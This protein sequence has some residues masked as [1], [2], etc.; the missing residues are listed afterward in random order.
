MHQFRV[1]RTLTGLSIPFWWQ[2]FVGGMFLPLIWTKCFQS[3]LFQH[4]AHTP[5]WNLL[6]GCNCHLFIYLLLCQEKDKNP[7]K[8][9]SAQEERLRN[10]IRKGVLSIFHFFIIWQSLASARHTVLWRVLGPPKRPSEGF[11]KVIKKV[12]SCK[13]Y[14]GLK[15]G[16]L[17]TLS[18]NFIQIG[19]LLYK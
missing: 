2:C 15:F 18:P 13:N 8:S 1:Q 12:N 10:K 17:L 9:T 7:L 19:P 6:R 4:N 11:L 16:P 5:W 14:I 3:L